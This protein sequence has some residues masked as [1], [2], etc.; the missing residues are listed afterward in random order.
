MW[1]AS[2]E[3]CFVSDSLGTASWFAN[4]STEFYPKPQQKGNPKVSKDIPGVP[5]SW[6]HHSASPSDISEPRQY[7]DIS[8]NPHSGSAI[9]SFPQVGGEIKNIWNHQPEFL[10]FLR[11]MPGIHDDSK[12]FQTVLRIIGCKLLGCCLLQAWVEKNNWWQIKENKSRNWKHQIRG[13][14][15][16][17]QLRFLR[18][19]QMRGSYR[20][21]NGQ[22][23]GRKSGREKEMRPFSIS[24]HQTATFYSKPLQ[25][26]RLSLHSVGGRHTAESARE[27]Y[28]V[29]QNLLRLIWDLSKG[30][31]TKRLVEIGL[32]W[33]RPRLD[34]LWE[35]LATGGESLLQV[36]RHGENPAQTPTKPFACNDTLE[37]VVVW[38]RSRKS[39]SISFLLLCTC[40]A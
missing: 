10:L 11:Q 18:K 28:A 15:F 34:S 4:T 27:S 35:T 37:T 1:H 40:L 3:Y 9:G 8:W 24:Y 32:V 14:T 30:S 29:T 13:T 6:I 7:A 39:S 21:P 20:S 31:P 22:T 17:L 33:S 2:V 23:H 25:T 5:N 12:L 26:G 16:L 36:Q 19:C 38:V